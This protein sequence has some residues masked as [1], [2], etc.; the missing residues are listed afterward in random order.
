LDV[1][2]TKNSRLSVE[3]EESDQLAL[4]FLGVGVAVAAILAG[5]GYHE[6]G[7]YCAN[8]CGE[9]AAILSV[10][11]REGGHTRYR[12]EFPEVMRLDAERVE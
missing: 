10:P 5:H 11:Q 1:K 7:G 8:R 12:V 3:V 4:S 6:L 2:H 9:R